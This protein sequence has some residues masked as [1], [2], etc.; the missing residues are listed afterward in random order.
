MTL[1]RS[2]ALA[3][4]VLLLAVGCASAGAPPP[5]PPAEP[6][7]APESAPASA[8]AAA[9]PAPEATTPPSSMAEDREEQKKSAG[10]ETLPEAE[11]ALDRASQELD[12]MYVAAG[13]VPRPSAP[14][15]GAATGA[16]APTARSEAKA[17]SG[18][19]DTACKAFDSLRRA[20]DA[21]CRLAGDDDARCARGKK[22][23]DSNGKRVA[24]CS[25]H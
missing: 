15:G 14:G 11:A 9:A 6:A 1:R 10:L 17:E 13:P 20:S 24:S 4:P 12:R 21:I 3:A 19:C 18:S 5:A 25:C 16:A 23:V 7:Q 2:L 22:L 8:P